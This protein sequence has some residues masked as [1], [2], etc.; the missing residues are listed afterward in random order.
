ML[1]L[2]SKYDGGDNLNRIIIGYSEKVMFIPVCPEQMGG[3]PTPRE[4][5]EITGGDGRDVLE[6]KVPVL[7]SD[8]IDVTPLFIRGAEEVLKLA[9][10]LGIKRA[11]L[12]SG[13][14]SC[15]YGRIR[16]GSF[17][18]IWREGNG[19]TTSL[20]KEHGIEVYTEDCLPSFDN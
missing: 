2:N 4:A 20:L 13:S 12:K 11:I 18:G 9:R 15:G 5:A 7:L 14:P 16:D 19:V 6:G 8:G 17:K 10:L 3:L 1:G